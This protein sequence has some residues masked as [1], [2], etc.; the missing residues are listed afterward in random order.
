MFTQLHEEDELARG[1]VRH[2]CVATCD[3]AEG[4]AARGPVATVA[5][6]VG[7]YKRGLCAGYDLCIVACV[8]AFEIA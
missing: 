6:T 3:T 1:I 8:S 2:P 5:V 4:L 7:W